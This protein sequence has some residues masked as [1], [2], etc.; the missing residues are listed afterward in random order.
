MQVL[1]LLD[2]GRLLTELIWTQAT[3][4]PFVIIFL[5]HF[6]ISWTLS[7]QHREFLSWFRH[8]NSF[9]ILWSAWEWDKWTFS[10]YHEGLSFHTTTSAIDRTDCLSRS[11]NDIWVITDGNTRAP[12]RLLRTTVGRFLVFSSHWRVPW[13]PLHLLSTVSQRRLLIIS[14]TLL[15]FYLL[16]PQLCCVHRTGNWLRG[17]GIA[18][19]RWNRYINLDW[20]AHKQALSI[21]L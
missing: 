14:T 16:S 20:K 5:M 3:C 15:L 13:Y 4:A 19:Q 6:K 8:W 10:C 2:I 12:W 18:I 7:W 9:S 11:T 21:V 17:E 1:L